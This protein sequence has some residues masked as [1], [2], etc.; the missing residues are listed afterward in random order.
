MKTIL[1]TI[2]LL[3]ALNASAQVV[4]YKPTSFTDTFVRTI[5]N[6]AQARAYFG[7]SGITNYGGSLTN[8]QL[9]GTTLNGSTTNS[10]ATASTIAVY[11]ANKVLGSG[12]A[13]SNVALLNGTNV[14]TGTN[15]FTLPVIATNTANTFAGNGAGLTSVTG[16]DSTKLPLAGG[17]M[18]ASGAAANILTLQ[19]AGDPYTGSALRFLSTEGYYCNMRFE[20][21]GGFHPLIM[22]F[23]INDGYQC[24]IQM[25][26]GGVDKLWMWPSSTGGRMRSQGDSFMFDHNNGSYTAEWLKYDGYVHLGGQNAGGVKIWNH[27]N[28]KQFF[29][30]ADYNSY[31]SY[32]DANNYQ[33]LKLTASATAVTLSAITAGTGADNIDIVLTPAGTGNVGIGTTSP[34]AVLHTRADSTSA[35]VELLRL[36]NGTAGGNAGNGGEI[37]FRDG[38]GNKVANVTSVFTGS[39]WVLKLGAYANEATVTVGTGLTIG[40]AGTAVTNYASATATL[41]FASIPVH[42][43]ED[44][45]ITVTGAVV[46]DTVTLGLPATVLAGVVYNAW[47]SASNTVTVRCNNFDSGSR[48]PASATYR[49]GVTSH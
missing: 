33:G 44:L 17:T 27:V 31:Y 45:T 46:N 32:T 36:Q 26:R 42:N 30:L 1:S 12:A 23:G 4:S 25:Q 18:T 14:F 24:G 39:A 37:T 9:Y 2:L 11:D 13:V 40:T 10:A 19:Q 5:V 47:V 8:S 48:D 49:V 35:I 29:T 20:Q 16:T 22:D 38:D 6:A 15:R 7:I 34:G 3:L 21:V 43:Y 41:N 28:L